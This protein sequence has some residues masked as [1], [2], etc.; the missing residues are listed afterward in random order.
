MCNKKAH[1]PDKSSA[2]TARLSRL[3][4][5]HGLVLQICGLD[6]EYLGLLDSIISRLPEPER[7]SLARD[8]QIR[9]R[10]Q[11]VE[12]MRHSDNP[13]SLYF[14]SLGRPPVASSVGLAV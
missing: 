2:S 9:D 10:L 1:T 8:A 3:E 12:D 6:A 4:R 5:E 7:A 13:Y 14:A 11:R